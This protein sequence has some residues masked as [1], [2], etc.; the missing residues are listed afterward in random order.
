MNHSPPPKPP[1]TDNSF[2]FELTDFAEAREAL[3]DESIALAAEAAR[4]VDSDYWIKRRRSRT[5]T[6]RALAGSTIDWLLRLPPDL[7]PNRL[8]QQ[9]PRLANQIADA[10]PDPKRC[11]SALDDL[12]S[13]KRGGRRGL[14][15]ELQNEVLMLRQHLAA[16]SG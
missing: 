3:D 7:R 1:A 13:D 10:W 6:D 12:L 16:A 4:P 5:A 15:L 2:E 11:L 14:P 9:V 8:S